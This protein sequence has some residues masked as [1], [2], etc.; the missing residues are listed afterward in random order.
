[1]LRAFICVVFSI[2]LTLCSFAPWAEADEEEG[3]G[4]QAFLGALIVTGTAPPI[5]DGVILAR[6]GRIT[7]VGERWAGDIPEDAERIDVSGKVI[8]PGLVN[9][10]GHVGGTQGL[11]SATEFHTA[12]IVAEQ[13]AR[14]ARYGVTSVFSLGGDRGAGLRAADER[15]R[16]GIDHARLF[17]AGP[18]IEATTP[19]DAER[20]VGRATAMQLDLIQ[21]RVDDEFDSV[22]KM[23]PHVY[24]RI[25]EKAH[26]VDL[27]VATHVYELADAKGVV[28]AGADMLARS[29]RDQEVDDEL[30]ALLKERNVCVCPALMREVAAFAYA[31]TPTFFDDPFFLNE[32]DATVLEALR[33]PA[34]QQEVTADPLTKRARDAF[35]IAKRN[36]KKLADAGVTIA[37]GTGSG[38]PAQFPGY[39]EHM[40]L[41]LMVEAGLTP[42]QV[43]RAATVDAARC[44]GEAGRVGSLDPGAWAD[45]IVLNADPSQDILNARQIDSVW[46]AGTRVPARK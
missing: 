15:E 27:R 42:G 43:L 2:G 14:Y 13:L 46:I 36:L 20:W 30:I 8:I 10:H 45:F 19:A 25:I 32:A 21:I 26:A 28:A 41:A 38:P 9:T 44:L 35:E 1:M 37:F 3:S 40:E 12:E 6:Y 16:Q 34:R 17:V 31:R 29:I 4:R 33:A 23:P 18:L 11:E 5:E 39:F 7:S 22:T 24:A